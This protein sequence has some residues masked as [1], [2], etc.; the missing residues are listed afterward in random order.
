MYAIRSY[1]AFGKLDILV[2][3]AGIASPATLEEISVDVI[4]KVMDVNFIGRITSY[5]V[6]YTKLLRKS[7]FKV[8]TSINVY[9]REWYFSRIKGFFCQMEHYYR[10]FT[11]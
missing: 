1:Y 11:T 8:V 9:Q 7:F 10:I 6:C 5:N 3:N 2:N 4:K